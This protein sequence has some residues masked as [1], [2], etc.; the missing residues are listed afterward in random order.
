G[1]DLDLM[2]KL[3]RCSPY[4]LQHLVILDKVIE[5]VDGKGDITI[6]PA[7]DVKGSHGKTARL[8]AFDEIH[9]MRDW[10]LLEAM[11]LDPTRKDAQLLYPS[12]ASIHHRP[13]APLFDL[14]A[15]A[16]RGDDPRFFVS[17]YAADWGTDPELNNLPTPEERANPSITP[18]D[19]LYLPQQKS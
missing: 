15:R 12:Y 4:L 7:G 1:D 13:G 10:S 5:R 17:W 6:L 9:T 2:K 11:Q 18:F 14:L 16:R 8:V 3:V 19:P